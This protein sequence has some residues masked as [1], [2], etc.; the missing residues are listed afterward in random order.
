[1]VQMTWIQAASLGA[2]AILTVS[3]AGTLFFTVSAHAARPK[4][5]LYLLITMAPFA[6][7]APVVGPVVDKARKWRRLVIAATCLGRAT[8]CVLMARDI[9][10]V[11]LFPEAFGA[12]LLQ[13]AYLVTKGAI[14][15]SLLS[16]QNKLVTANARLARIALVA[17]VVAMGLGAGVFK[18]GGAKWALYLAALV[19]VGAAVLSVGLP[20]GTR[21][22]ESELET[23][24]GADSVTAPP[25]S[26]A[27]TKLRGRSSRQL[28][29]TT[30]IRLAASAMGLLRGAVGFLTFLVLFSLKQSSEPTWFYGAVIAASGLGAFAGA[31]LAPGLRRRLDEES[32]L[33]GSLILS[34]LGALLDLFQFGRAGLPLVAF[35]LGL[36][37]S[38]ARVAFDSLVQERSQEAERGR[39]FA[40]FETR[41]QLTWVI[42]A[43][44]AVVL[45]LDLTI[46]LIVLAAAMGVAT[47]SYLSGLRGR[48]NSTTHHAFLHLRRSSQS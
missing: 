39:A 6:L 32:L 1:M 10:S 48:A 3:L 24:R 19:Y 12:L 41:F 40:R 26:P 11:L 29:D 9:N 33:I 5:L 2:D 20:A 35:A 8:M 43:F 38:A 45:H 18:L 25:S 46:G 37:A 30:R 36:A 44:L 17:G 4:V 21:H 16:D 27:M 23:G 47:F 42:G 34:G 15:P 14:V 22:E 7:V 31:S 28:S 13:K